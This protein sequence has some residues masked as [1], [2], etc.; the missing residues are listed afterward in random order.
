M[1]LNE[2]LSQ[3]KTEKNERK[4][5]SVL[6]KV[7]IRQISNSK[8]NG[9]SDTVVVEVPEFDRKSEGPL[10]KDLQRVGRS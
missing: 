7:K 9:S 3:W 8:G 1:F 6:Q 2:R 10:L 4:K 5:E